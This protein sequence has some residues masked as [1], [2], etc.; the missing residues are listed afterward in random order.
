MCGMVHAVNASQDFFVAIIAKKTVL[1]TR[2]IHLFTSMRIRIRTQ[3]ANQCGSMAD[4]DPSQT[5]PS[6]E[7]EFL[8]EKYIYVSIRS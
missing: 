3:G 7:V 1:W 4:Q 2:R 8:H 6:L 5:L